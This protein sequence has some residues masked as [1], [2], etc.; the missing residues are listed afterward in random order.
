MSKQTSPGW[1][2]PTE[3]VRRLH[4]RLEAIGNDYLAAE[5]EVCETTE[6]A[7]GLN[8]KQVRA[9][10]V[11]LSIHE[12]LREL[13]VFEK[14]SGA[15]VLHD[16]A[17]ALHDV[18][19][20]G[21]PRLFS[22]SQPG[23]RGGDGIDRN[24][25]KIFAVLAV[26]FLIEAHGWQETRATREVSRRLSAAG[27][28]GRKGGPLSQTTVQDWCNK[29]NA[30]SANAAEVSIAK[31]VESRLAD[32]RADPDWPGTPENALVWIDRLSRDPLLR[33]KYG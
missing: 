26:R 25:L 16:V 5:W 19:H 9:A 21:N 10:E 30:N 15:A 6:P 12:A 4:E 2:D 32:W 3:W 31:A 20:G 14:S 7:A 29:A 24:Y 13:P 22:P 18:V 23:K 33:S 28:T 17:C 8:L 11:L 1:P 27:A